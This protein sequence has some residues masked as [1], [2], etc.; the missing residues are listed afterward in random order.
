M[1]AQRW[2]GATSHTSIGSQFSLPGRLLPTFTNGRF[3]YR[4]CI[5]YLPLKYAAT[6]MVSP[7]MSTMVLSA[8]CALTPKI[9]RFRSLRWVGTTSIFRRARAKLRISRSWS[10]R[11]SSGP[12]AHNAAMTSC[13]SGPGE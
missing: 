6:D 11:T 12:R 8:G 3:G 2:P 10:S 9:A 1:L 7:L 5:L 13:M 4:S